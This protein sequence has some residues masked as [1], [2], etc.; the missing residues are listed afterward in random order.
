MTAVLLSVQPPARTLFWEVTFDAGHAPLFGV[1]AAAALAL[2]PGPVSWSGSA[3]VRHYLLAFGV[4]VVVGALSEAAQGGTAE[5]GEALDVVRDAAGAAA[6]LLVAAALDRSLRPHLPPRRI[7]SPRVLVA[8]GAALLAAAFAPLVLAGALYL[9][10]DAAFPTIWDPGAGWPSRFSSVSTSARLE[11][12]RA[13]SGRGGGTEGSVAR[14]TFLP[15]EYPG[16]VIDEPYPDWRGYGRLVFDAFSGEAGPTRVVLRIDDDR[17]DG[18][19]EDRFNRS[20]T[21]RPGW[22]AVSIP[23]REVRSA[24]R[25]RG[26]DMARIRRL[27]LFAVRPTAPFS[28]C[29]G[30]MRLER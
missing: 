20:L 21:L 11:L 17:H 1:L 23:L 22:N 7:S 13:P 5:G 14:V 19:Y 8:A 10:R 28:I 12:V 30:A 29:L 2:S 15:S 16:L 9:R 24:P 27:V 18:R 25:G 6:A 26:M 4:A 3:R